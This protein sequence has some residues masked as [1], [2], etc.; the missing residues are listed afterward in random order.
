MDKFVHNSMQLDMAAYW[1]STCFTFMELVEG[2][3][4]EEAWLEEEIYPEVLERLFK[5]QELLEKVR[6]E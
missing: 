6:L 5:V 3:D 1:L 4:I 2:Y